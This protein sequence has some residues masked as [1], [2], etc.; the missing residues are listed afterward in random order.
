MKKILI[1]L[2]L[3]M[4]TVPALAQHWN[5]GHRHHGHARYYG[6]S[7]WVAPLI[8]GGVVGAAIMNRPA[9]A[10]TIIVQQQPVYVPPDIEG[11]IQNKSTVHPY[12]GPTPHVQKAD[13]L[14][15]RRR[16]LSS[17]GAHVRRLLR[18][19]CRSLQR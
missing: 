9:Q 17:R 4:V 19:T 14:S 8:I 3:L 18:M 15:K 12:C 5:H 1:S 6:H 7:G 11:T 2:A 10:D 13:A 16:R